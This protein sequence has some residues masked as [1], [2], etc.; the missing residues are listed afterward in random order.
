[1][2]KKR[3]FSFAVVLAM[4]SLAGAGTFSYQPW[5]SDADSGVSAGKIYTHAVKFQAADGVLIPAGNGVSFEGDNNTQGTN[6]RLWNIPFPWGPGEHTTNIT[7]LGAN[8][9]GTSS[10]TSFVYGDTETVHPQLVLSSLTPGKEYIATFY[11]KGW[12]TGSRVVDIIADDDPNDPGHIIRINQ[13]QYGGGNGL[14][15][16]YRYTAP[17]SGQIVFTFDRVDTAANGPSWHHYAF[18]N[19]VDLPAYVYIQPQPLQGAFMNLTVNL[20]FAAIPLPGVTLTNPTYDLYWGTDPA[21]LTKVVGLTTGSYELQGLTEATTYHWKVEV[22]DGTTRIYSSDPGNLNKTWTF[23]TK[24]FSPATK[25]LEYPMNDPNGTVVRET[26]GNYNG[27]AVNLD[28]PNE[29]GS[30]WIPGLIGN[31]LNLDGI[32]SYADLGGEAPVPFGAGKAFSVSA[33]FKTTDTD[34]P[35]FAF[36]SSTNDNPILCVAVGFDGVNS[37][38]NTLRFI[39]RDTPGTLFRMTGAVVPDGEWNHVVLSRA[40]DGTVSM[41]LNG[42]FC[43]S[44]NDNLVAYEVDWRLLG[45]DRRWI[46][47]APGERRRFLDGS[48][49]T[50]TIWEGALK[51][52][53]IDEM[54][55]VLR[56]RLNPTPANGGTGIADDVTLSWSP[57]VDRYPGATYNIYLGMDPDLTN[58]LDGATGLPVT[59]FK[60][61]E[62][63]EFETRYFWKVETVVD[64]TVIYTSPTWSFVTAKGTVGRFSVLPWTGDADSKIASN[65]TY[66][67]AVKFNGRI[68][69]GAV[70]ATINGVNFEDDED[71]GGANWSL[72]EP[73]RNR[74]EG[75]GV[76]VGGNSANLLHN[77]FYGDSDTVHPVLTL[78]GL[79]VGTQYVT[80]FYTVGFGGPVN[81]DGS[82]GRRV[83]ITAS[84]NPTAPWRVDENGA[85]S[86][87]G[88]LIKYKFTAT[89]DTIGFTFD[90]Y[91][92]GDSWHHYAFSNEVAVLFDV[93]PTPATRTYVDTDVVLSWIPD[94]VGAAQGVT[95]N[96]LLGTDPTMAT[97]LIDVPG[98]TEATYSPSDLQPA[99]RYYWTVKAN[100]NGQVVATAPT[101]TF[102]TNGPATPLVEWKFDDT[103]GTTLTETHMGLNGTLMYEDPNNPVY[104][105]WVEGLKS[106]ALQLNG[107]DQFVDL[108]DVSGLSAPAGFAFSISGYFK[109]SDPEGPIFA[110][111]PPGIFC[112]YVGF[113]GADT[114]PGYF[115]FISAA[116]GL[117]RITGPKVDDG[118]WHHYAVTRSAFGEIELFVDGVSYGT[119][120]DNALAYTTG[121]GAF[122]TDK[123]WLVDWATSQPAE[124]MH[125]NG[126]IDETT[127]W[128]NVLQ[129]D[130]IQAMASLIPPLGDVNTDGFVNLADLAIVANGWLTADLPA[131]INRSGRVD[132]EDFDILSQDWGK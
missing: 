2:N 34:G 64:G 1:M 68:A 117:R 5:T 7:G 23:T 38:P 19:E 121:E 112:V 12:E 95:W 52:S 99:T 9:T 4:V 108:G 118:R 28:D 60:P 125:L 44:L 11:A 90:A 96:L 122:G 46:N 82:G 16:K 98:L 74:Y 79:T 93:I 33:Y 113:D 104:P 15:V 21:Q 58:S 85:G 24:S 86:G 66:T 91:T 26:I 103:T 97:T 81:P 32:D 8:L 75:F 94:P 115:R 37:L 27:T 132:L 43:G 63:L 3:V 59:Q 71:F 42:K 20:Y 51:Q 6:W 25:V 48:I 111:R 30:A 65:K 127:I 29:G 130:Q 101:W 77:F 18:S 88:Q 45:A 47:S 100:R 55:N 83:D 76:N 10:T 61:T 123:V 87:N 128:Q 116:D 41:Y 39:S 129:L 73:A 49:D 57:A 56:Y 62:P 35:I 114:V 105:L 50:V 102:V 124:R 31:C 22:F 67:H 92:T 126:L 131:D 70:F 78:T 119:T 109:T 110:L 69:D 106:N 89:T 40:I 54:V 120:N 72:S 53:Q 14:L 80:T 36:R 17:K 107:V 13:D 84:D